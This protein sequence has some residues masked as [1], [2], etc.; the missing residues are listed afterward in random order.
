METKNQTTEIDE[1]NFVA[2]E[3]NENCSTV[4]ICEFED[5]DASADEKN[6]SNFLTIVRNMMVA[7]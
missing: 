2:E 6:R 4:V 3:S 1:I 5:E 7:F